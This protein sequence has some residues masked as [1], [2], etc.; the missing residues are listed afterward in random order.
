MTNHIQRRIAFKWK[1][2]IIIAFLAVC[3][4]LCWL[5]LKKPTIEKGYTFFD[6]NVECK[7]KGNGVYVLRHYIS[8]VT[9]IYPFSDGGAEHLE[10]LTDAA[11]FQIRNKVNGLPNLE[12]IKE[13]YARHDYYKSYTEAS[14]VMYKALQRYDVQYAQG[15]KDYMS[16]ESFNLNPLPSK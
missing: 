8:N 5:W 12:Y 13:V 3:A 9:E 16:V 4:T 7:L 6:V 14:D 1:L 10:R 2:T 11:I 15:G